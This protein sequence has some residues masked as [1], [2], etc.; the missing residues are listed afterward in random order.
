MDGKNAEGR[1]AKVLNEEE[2]WETRMTTTTRTRRQ[3]TWTATGTCQNPPVR[4][5]C[6][7]FPIRTK[8]CFAI[9]GAPLGVWK[10][11]ITPTISAEGVEKWGSS[12]TVTV[13]V[14]GLILADSSTYMSSLS[15]SYNIT[16]YIQPSLAI[17]KWEPSTSL[18]W[19]TRSR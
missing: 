3:T 12:P 14:L 16:R 13:P 18:Q 11:R 19:R 7:P 8:R 17:F 10:W 1:V 6:T 9:R 2:V 15:P 5:L 4:W